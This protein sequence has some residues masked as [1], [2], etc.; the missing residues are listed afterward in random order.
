VRE[1]RRITGLYTITAGD[2]MGARK[3]DDVIARCSYPMDVHNPTGK[4]T[5]LR[6]LPPGESYDIPLRSLIPQN[7]RNLL[8]AG[9]CM[10]G[11]HVAL[12]SYR[13]MPTTMATGQAAGV[14]AANASYEK[15]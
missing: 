12:S 9:R 2:V 1:T 4:G 5:M 10:S 3:F 14:C 13:V 8:V 7:T 15:L 11:E 6:R